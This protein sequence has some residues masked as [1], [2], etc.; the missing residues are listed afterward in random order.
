ME[1][2]GFRRRCNRSKDT[3]KKGQSRCRKIIKPGVD[4]GSKK[5]VK[6]EKSLKCLMEVNL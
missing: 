6:S 1:E 4:G 3:D 5:D 2:R